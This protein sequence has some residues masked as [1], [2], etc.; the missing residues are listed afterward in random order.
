MAYVEPV[1]KRLIAMLNYMYY[2]YYYYHY[3]G[4]GVLCEQVQVAVK[5]LRQ[6]VISNSGALED[7]IREV[8]LMHRIDHKHLIRLYGIVMSSP[9]M[10]VSRGGGAAHTFVV[11]DTVHI[12]FAGGHTYTSLSTAFRYGVYYPDVYMCSMTLYACT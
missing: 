8:H 11:H 12:L 1:L 4:H 7:F 6:D 5:I 10:M 9:M 2:C 3:Y